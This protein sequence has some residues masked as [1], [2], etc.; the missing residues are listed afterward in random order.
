MNLM[1]LPSLMFHCEEGDIDY[2]QVYIGTERFQDIYVWNTGTGALTVDAIIEGEGHMV[3]RS[4]G[5]C[6]RR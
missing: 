5:G 2:G 6:T 3:N 4:L 1:K